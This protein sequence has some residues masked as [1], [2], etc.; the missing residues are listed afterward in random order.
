MYVIF[1]NE[2]ELINYYNKHNEEKRL[3]TKHANIEFI[4]AMKYIKDYL[5]DGYKILD[6]GAGTGRYSLELQRDGYDVTA[7]E[8]V[9]HNLRY[10]EKKG[11]K[12]YQ[13]NA[14]DL[15][16]FEDNSFDM[17]LLFGPMY[18]LLTMDEKVKALEEAKRVSKKYIFISYCM[19]EF[20]VIYHG[21]MEGYIKEDIKNLDNT[22]KVLKDNDNLYS[23]VRL[24]DIDYLK[25]K[26]NLK[27]VKIINQDGPT[28]Y[29]K[30]IV[31][32][33][34]DE[35]YELFINYHLS[36]CER[37]ELLGSGRHILDILEK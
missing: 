28:E 25:D 14:I 29:I 34:D 12:C 11:I 6:V 18:H 26:C 31:N 13:G 10:I 21:F 36:T 9:K 33:M 23:Y 8:L 5:K 4:T 35:T 24:E 1:M 30:N 27:R 22:F 3:L 19:N 7:V 16:R 17:V 37:L 20:A 32:K 15:S 2:K